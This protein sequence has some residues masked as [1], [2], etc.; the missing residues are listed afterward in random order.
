MRPGTQVAHGVNRERRVPPVHENNVRL[1]KRLDDRFMPANRL[2]T[3]SVAL[4]ITLPTDFVLLK[5]P[6]CRSFQFERELL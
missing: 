4:V 2:S 1:A 3:F 5:W 6:A